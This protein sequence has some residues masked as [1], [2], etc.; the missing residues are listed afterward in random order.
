MTKTLYVPLTP[1]LLRDLDARALCNLRRP[2]D[3]A[4]AL[5][6]WAIRQLGAVPPDP[7][8]E[9]IAE[10]N[11]RGLFASGVVHE[12]GRDAL[13]SHSQRLDWALKPHKTT[14]KPKDRIRDPFAQRNEAHT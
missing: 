14:L 13:P 7:D 8:A 1:D 2:Q 12:Y 11:G 5:L 6:A 3:E 10:L 9:I 4:A